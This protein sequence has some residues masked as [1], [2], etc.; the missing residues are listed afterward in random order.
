MKTLKQLR[1]EY[2]IKSSPQVSPEDLVLEE[3]SKSKKE[4]DDTKESSLSLI[5]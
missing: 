2:D 4:K 3:I 5:S 1:E